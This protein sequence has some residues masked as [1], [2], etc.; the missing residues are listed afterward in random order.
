MAD[1]EPTACGGGEF[2]VAF[3]FAPF[4]LGAD[5]AM[6]MC[7]GVLA[8]MN[9]SLVE[10]T[11]HLAMSGKKAVN[12]SDTLHRAS[13]H[14]GILHTCAIIGK[15]GHI[16]KKS[17]IVHTFMAETLTCDSSERKHF[18]LRIIGDAIKLLLEILYRIGSGL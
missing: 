3:H 14:V 15:S 6:S 5:A 10:Q 12:F 7:T 13:H 2:Y 11:L 4:T 9:I 17:F 18:Y 8:V 1:M 16:R